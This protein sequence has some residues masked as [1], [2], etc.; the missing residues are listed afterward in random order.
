MA[1]VEL[2]RHK[3]CHRARYRARFV[4]IEFFKQ[5]GLRQ[6][7]LPPGDAGEDDD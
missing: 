7:S 3:E 5:G 6:E 1:V 4:D 2:A